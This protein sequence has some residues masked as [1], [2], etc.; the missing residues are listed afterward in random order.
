MI[1]LQL[2]FGEA[3]GARV[4]PDVVSYGAA[5]SACEGGL[6]WEEALGE[7]PERASPTIMCTCKVPCDASATKRTADIQRNH[8]CIPLLV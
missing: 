3:R 7:T 1:I 5:I 6:Q 4:A 2:A 8:L